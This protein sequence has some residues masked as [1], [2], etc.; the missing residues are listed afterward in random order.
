[1]ETNQKS[2][3]GQTIKKFLKP[4]RRK[5]LLTIIITIFS[6]PLLYSTMPSPRE[7]VISLILLFLFFPFFVLSI[8]L[9]I[10]CDFSGYDALCNY[11]LVF[12]I[13]F[14]TEIIYYYLISCLII[15]IHDKFK[16]RKERISH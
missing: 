3:K 6:F 15:F 7:P 2:K 16:G 5:I 12:I 11:S 1:M 4:D 8:I 14:I 9:S 13:G 10:L